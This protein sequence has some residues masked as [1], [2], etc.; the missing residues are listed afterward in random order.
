MPEI[1][2][3]QTP[4]MQDD[5]QRRPQR[6]RRHHY[7]HRPAWMSS[8][9]ARGASVCLQ[10]LGWGVIVAVPL[11]V[12]WMCISSVLAKNSIER[13]VYVASSLQ[14]TLKDGDTK[15][16]ASSV[17]ELADHIENAYGQ[18]KQ[19]IWWMAAQLPYVGQDVTAVRQAVSVMHDVAEGALPQLSQVLRTVDLKAISVQGGTVRIPGLADAA[20]DLEVVS[21]VVT[22]ADADMQR[23][24]SMHFQ[25]LNDMLDQGKKGFDSL[26]SA[27]DSVAKVSRVLPS[28]LDLDGAGGGERTY[29]V[30]AQ[31]NAELRATG[32]IPG[33]LGLLHVS[34]GALTLD[35]FVSDADFDV[36]PDGAIALTGDERNLYGDKIGRWIQNTTLTP[37]FSRTGQIVKAMWERQFGGHI[38]GVLSIDP[39]LLQHMLSVTGAVTVTDGSYTMTLDGSNAATKLMSQVYRDLPVERQDAFFA[40]AAKTAFQHMLDSSRNDP[41]ALVRAFVESAQGGHFLMWSAHEDEQ[42]VLGA[43]Q[44][45]GALPRSETNPVAGLFFNDSSG[46]KMGAYL[47]RDVLFGFEKRLANGSRQ[48]V[49]DVTLTNTLSTDDVASTPEYVLGMNSDGTASGDVGEIMYVYA[50]AGGSILDWQFPDGSGFDMTASHD[51]LTLGVKQIRLKPGESIRFTVR[52]QS[53]PKAADVPMQLRQTPSAAQ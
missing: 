16:T 9:A 35:P 4:R 25:R 37:D 47:K 26:A 49:L 46:S 48:Y 50:P 15:A 38:D 34:D 18:T 23:V 30:L 27:L 3:T 41:M 1:P 13:A 6:R 29:V 20:D 7:R 53:S 17:D 33:S 8:P 39:V 44:V 12:M 45:G 21:S 5:P 10:V 51:G 2:Q 36:L 42:T 43:S 32:G 28:M 19:P 40:L 14:T 24:P 52:F 11:I 31:N 22:R